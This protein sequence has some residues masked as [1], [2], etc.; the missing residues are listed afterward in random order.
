MKMV[1]LP[2]FCGENVYI[3]PMHIAAVLSIT[4]ELTE[5]VINCSHSIMVKC[6]VEEVFKAVDEVTEK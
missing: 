4:D 1:K 2:R 6:T 5:I 3:N